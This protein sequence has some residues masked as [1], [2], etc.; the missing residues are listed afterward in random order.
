VTFILSFVLCGLYLA[1]ARHMQVVD[2]PNHRSSHAGPTPHGG[3]VGLVSAFLCA[4]FV[5]HLLQGPLAVPYLVIGAGALLLMLLGIADDLRDLSV[6]TRLMTCLVLCLGTAAYL[7]LETA[8]LQGW[9]AFAS[10]LA[11]GVAL[12]VVLNFYNFMDGIDG[13]AASQAILAGTAAALLAWGGDGGSQYA[14]VCALLAASHLGFLAWNWPPAK[15]FMG[16]AGSVATGFTL[17]ALALWGEISGAVG[18]ATWLVLLAVF[19]TD[20][21]WTL[22]WR[23]FTGQPFTQ[24]H[25]S[26]AYQRLSLRWNS[27]LRV[28]L[29]FAAVNLF[30]LFPIGF[31]VHTNPGHALILVILAYLPLVGFMAK[32]RHLH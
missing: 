5:L 6:T 15:L 4:L 7:L 25:R 23:M 31:A 21:G 12:L 18:V 10:V 30:W 17:A 27:H 2:T 8:Q 28:D 19:I 22:L 26:H 16:D 3:G 24:P 29:V 9:T 14:L 20:A 11:A 13:I 32:I 1:W